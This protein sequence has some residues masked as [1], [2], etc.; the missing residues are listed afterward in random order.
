MDHVKHPLDWW[1]AGGYDE[2]MR[3]T[4]WNLAK[5][6][7]E[8][9]KAIKSY[10]WNPI[11]HTGYQELRERIMAGERCSTMISN[12]LAPSVIR[13]TISNL[14]PM[15]LHPSRLERLQ[16][17]VQAAAVDHTIDYRR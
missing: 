8:V 2:V 16:S 11:G 10:G 12:K 4:G 15:Q 6:R 17:A 14:T 3:H 1:A 13:N 7:R 5:A 9:R